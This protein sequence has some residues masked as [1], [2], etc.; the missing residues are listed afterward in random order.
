MSRRLETLEYFKNEEER[1]RQ[2]YT[3]GLQ[4]LGLNE[5]ML[6][7][8][9]VLDIG[10]G[11]GYIGYFLRQNGVKCEVVDLD[12][13]VCSPPGAVAVKGHALW[14]PFR[15][16]T[17]DVVISLGCM[18]ILATRHRDPEQAGIAARD[19]LDEAV[20]V[21]ARGGS[22]RMHYT[23]EVHNVNARGLYTWEAMSH[24]AV[25][26]TIKNYNQTLN[27]TGK[28]QASTME[29]TLVIYKR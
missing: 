5:E 21:T 14:L 20:R 22:V 2:F 23:P 17:F 15:D 26:K 1:Y 16:E 25:A 3:D 18:P 19:A 8:K 29:N 6:E 12:R 24:F 7:G 27:E 10:A 11:N 4:R 28:Y 13:S 9:R